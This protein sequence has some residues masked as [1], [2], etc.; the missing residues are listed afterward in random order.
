MKGQAAYILNMYKG[1]NTEPTVTET[2]VTIIGRKY[3]TVS[4]GNRYE[5]DNNNPYGLIESVD[6]GDRTKKKSRVYDLEIPA[7]MKNISM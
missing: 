4:N 1:R 2:S 7:V 3:V 6:W 5:T